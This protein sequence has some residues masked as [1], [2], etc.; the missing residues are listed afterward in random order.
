MGSWQVTNG[1]WLHILISNHIYSWRYVRYNL[2]WSFTIYSHIYIYIYHYPYS[3]TNGTTII[4]KYFPWVQKM[5][6]NFSGEFLPILPGQWESLHRLGDAA[7]YRKPPYLIVKPYETMVS[8]Q[9]VP[10]K[11]ESFDGGFA[12]SHIPWFDYGTFGYTILNISEHSWIF[13]VTWPNILGEY[14][15]SSRKSW[16]CRFCELLCFAHQKWRHHGRR[17]QWFPCL[18]VILWYHEPNC[19]FKIYYRYR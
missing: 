19:H 17:F 18:S 12:T 2:H 8:G 16:G 11:P 1:N 15:G 7:N 14:S 4:Y 13:G 9:D 10:C 3:D 5:V 6:V